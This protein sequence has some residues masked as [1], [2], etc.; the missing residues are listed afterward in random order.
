MIFAK[1]AFY[2]MGI[3]WLWYGYRMERLRRDTDA[4]W[5]RH[6]CIAYVLVM[7]NRTAKM[8]DITNGIVFV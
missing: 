1:I 5:V 7:G 3:I 8:A 4:G 2:H 6:R